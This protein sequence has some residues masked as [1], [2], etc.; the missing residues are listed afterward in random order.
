[1]V[2]RD[3]IFMMVSVWTRLIQPGL[4]EIKRTFVG[5]S[6][7]LVGISYF[8]FWFFRTKVDSPG[9]QDQPQV[10]SSWCQQA[11]VLGIVI[12]ILGT[13]PVWLTD[14]YI[15]TGMYADRFALPGM[16][17]ASILLVGL[18]S[19][20]GIRYK[21]RSI[22]L[23]IMIS[24]AI[25][26][27]FRVSNDFRWDW[28]NQ[29]RF[30]WQ[31]YWRA[32]ELEP[33][34]TVFS[35][36][37]IFSFAG[38]Y[39]TAFAINAFYGSENN[40]TELPYWFI[41]LDSGFHRDPDAYLSG[42]NLSKSLRNYSFLGNSLHSIVLDFNPDSGSCLWILDERDRINL[43]MPGLTWEALPLSD[44]DRIHSDRSS[45]LFPSK[46]IFGREPDHTWCY[47]YQNATA[48]RHNG[49]WEGVLQIKDVVDELGYGPNNRLE[50]IP[51][52]DAYAR[53][54]RWAEAGELTLSAYERA[55]I[56]RKTFCTLW[57]SFSEMDLDSAPA[58]NSI[59]A[60][61]RTLGCD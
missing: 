18:L 56:A 25:G 8:L 17:G 52:I 42:I 44:L 33:G 54:G 1:M 43:S 38:E 29:K 53:L 22:I 51:F 26:A 20:I 35:D 24:L 32:P 48:A 55:P 19:S 49:D 30:F 61:I 50:W 41:E 3:F 60:V 27:H 14:K 58:S 39:P 37:S 34:T 31:L 9:E 13:L 7:I 36:G 47:Y 21:S 16:L 59:D 23:S 11:A 2:V 57:D 45:I 46:A 12:F 15:S 4:I 28:V 10:D 5:F 6:W 40:V